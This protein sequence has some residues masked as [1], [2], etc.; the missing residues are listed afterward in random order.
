MKS[1]NVRTI[2]AGA[3]AALALGKVTLTALEL[4]HGMRLAGKVAVVCGGSRGL[5][6]ALARALA[7]KGC[8]VAICARSAEDLEAARSEI[9]RLGVAVYAEACD[10]RRR[11]DVDR[12]LANVVA[13]LGPIDVL[14]ANAATISVAPIEALDVRDFDEAMEAIWKT[15]LHPVMGVL[16][17]MRE[18]RAGTIAL[19]TSIGG[20]IGV[21]HLAPYS[22][23]KFATVGFAQ[24]LRA[25]VAKHGVH[26]LTVVP[27][28]MRTGSPVHASFKGDPVK[29]YAWFTASANAPLLTIDA[30]RAARRIVLAIERG[31][32]EITYTPAARFAARTHDLAPGVWNE[33]LALAARLL[34]R[35]G[36][37]TTPREGRE[38]EDEAARSPVV[39]AVR[40]RNGR[41]A[42]RHGQ[43]RAV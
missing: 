15:A 26:V 10:L 20:K 39:A 14:V 41:F 29:E 13:R 18:R 8:S 11:A 6:L 27:G 36:G 25:E 2:L 9:A 40:A 31:A 34:P 38:V 17:S 43:L 30:D 33:L 1:T 4:R 22:A 21:P 35:D 12:F 16:P 32:S 37:V 24:A 42:R 28:L 3:A 23:A 19:V 5:G 7:A